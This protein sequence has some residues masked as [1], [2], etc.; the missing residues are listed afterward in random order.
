MHIIIN[1]IQSD[2][3]YLN[4]KGLDQKIV[5]LMET[6]YFLCFFY[7]ADDNLVELNL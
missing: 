1:K 2:E 4:H 6:L 3:Q 5:N 7:I